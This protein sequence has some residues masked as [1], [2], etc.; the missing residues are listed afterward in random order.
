MTRPFKTDKSVGVD[1]GRYRVHSVGKL[2]AGKGK[3]KLG[4]ISVIEDDSRRKLGDSVRQLGEYSFYLPCFLCRQ[5]T[6][7][8]VGFNDGDRLD[9]KCRAR[10][11][12]VV[13]KSLYLVSALDLDGN[14]EASVSHRDDIVLK[15]F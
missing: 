5:L 6:Q 15:I 1:R 4:Y 9:E 3:R 8:V 13:D 11:R 14:Y 10:C 7:V 12:R 2:G